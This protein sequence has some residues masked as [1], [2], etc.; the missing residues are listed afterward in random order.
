MKQI[1]F[2]IEGLSMPAGTE[3]I[4]SDL[5]NTLHKAGFD[6]SFV[7]LSTSIESYYKLAEGIGVYSIGVSFSRRLQAIIKLRKLLI[8]ESPDFIVNVGIAMGQISIPATLGLKTK[9]IGWEHFNLYAGSTLGYY[10]RLLAAKLSYKTVV[11]TQ[12][13]CHDYLEKVSANVVCIPNFTTRFID[14]KS[15]LSSKKVL[16]VGRLTSQKGYD[17]LLEAWKLIARKMPDWE[18][19]II[20]S[21]ED[22]SQLKLQAQHLDL[23]ESVFFIPATNDIKTYYEQASLYIMSSR[24]EGMPMVLIEAKM[25]GLPCVSFNCPNGPDEVIRDFVDG[26]VVKFGDVEQLAEATLS[27]MSNKNQLK[28]FGEKAKKDAL[29]RYTSEVAVR[30]WSILFER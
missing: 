20:G 9:V 7:V 28:T 5:V 1:F 12:K 2:L 16:S 23:L 19:Y 27:L 24:F 17:L 21:G 29:M 3:R 13:D 25:C 18:L 14:S 22:E 26:R 4:A 10:W 8:N 30:A 15:D 6:V 11:L